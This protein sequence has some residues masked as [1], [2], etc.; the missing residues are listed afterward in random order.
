[1]KFAAGT[2]VQI[3]ERGEWIGPFTVTNNSGRTEDHIVLTG[4]SGMF[5]HYADEFNTRIDPATKTV[6]V[7]FR[8]ADGQLPED[9]SVH[10]GE[11]IQ[12]AKNLV[13]YN[14]ENLQL[15]SIT[16]EFK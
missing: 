5:E 7:T 9:V 6:T 1:M 15:S 10:A 16:I 3:M 8:Y 14:F 11:T 13:A 2:R 12:S 4:R